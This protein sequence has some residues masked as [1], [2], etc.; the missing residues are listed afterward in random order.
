MRE[1]GGGGGRGGHERVELDKTL[2]SKYGQS[3]LRKASEKK[4]M[5]LL[6]KVLVQTENEPDISLQ[7]GP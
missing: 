7:H 4:Q 5:L 3:S 6:S 2:S 1:R